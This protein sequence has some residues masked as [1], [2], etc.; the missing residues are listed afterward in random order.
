MTTTVLKKDKTVVL[1]RC[2]VYFAARKRERSRPHSA[3][4]MSH[5]VP[6]PFPK[7]S[8]RLPL[9]HDWSGH[10]AYIAYTRILID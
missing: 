7:L 10:Y 2:C 8:N 1:L 9:P 5:R 3:N 6:R 4:D